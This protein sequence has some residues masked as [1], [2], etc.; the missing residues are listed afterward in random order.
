MWLSQVALHSATAVFFET[1]TPLHM[2]ATGSMGGVWTREGG[3]AKNR[4]IGRR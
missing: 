1:S 4:A 3:Y 2:L